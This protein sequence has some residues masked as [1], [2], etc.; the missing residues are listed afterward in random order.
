MRTTNL[1][2]GWNEDISFP[3]AMFG[4]GSFLFLLFRGTLLFEKVSPVTL[5]SA[6]SCEVYQGDYR[7]LMCVCSLALTVYVCTAC[8]EFVVL[9]V[10]KM[11]EFPIKFRMLD[12]SDNIDTAFPY[13]NF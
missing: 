7:G 5:S 9:V 10:R 2:N 4:Y 11:Y 3:L 8:F 13:G 6:T 1:V 12:Y